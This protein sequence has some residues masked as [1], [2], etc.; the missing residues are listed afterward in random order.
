MH[1][2]CACR[3]ALLIKMALMVSAT[4]HARKHRLTE[5]KVVSDYMDK[6]LLKAYPKAIEVPDKHENLPLHL[7][8]SYKASI[9]VVK[10]L[11]QAY[12]QA[13]E[14]TQKDGWDYVE[15]EQEI[16][17]QGRRIQGQQYSARNKP[18]CHDGLR[19]C[20]RKCWH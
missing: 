3:M 18:K 2:K 7:A 19:L 11:L 6:T 15:R 8:L 14:I 16:G 1:S 10:T 12:P 5:C 20:N 13:V 17:S 9:G 4:S